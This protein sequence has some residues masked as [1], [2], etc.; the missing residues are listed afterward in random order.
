MLDGRNASASARL[1]RHAALACGVVVVE[2][3]L[4]RLYLTLMGEAI[5]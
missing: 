5:P 3:L 4:F 1:V 2:L